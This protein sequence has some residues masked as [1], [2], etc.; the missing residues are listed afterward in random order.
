MRRCVG[1]RLDRLWRLIRLLGRQDHLRH[2]LL[3]APL[4]LHRLAWR[5]RRLIRLLG[6][7]ARLRPHPLRAPHLRQ[8]LH[9]HRLDRR[10]QQEY[11]FG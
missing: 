5:L 2:H 10:G 4:H 8:P 7:Q 9:L 3:Q 11:R 6:R 1:P